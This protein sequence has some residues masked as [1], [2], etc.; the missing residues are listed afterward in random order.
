MRL[1]GATLNVE[2]LSKKLDYQIKNLLIATRKVIKA[3]IITY[4]KIGIKIFIFLI[5]FV[6]SGTRKDDTMEFPT[7]SIHGSALAP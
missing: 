7:F 1:Q 5:Q 3:I 4:M 2:L 6:I